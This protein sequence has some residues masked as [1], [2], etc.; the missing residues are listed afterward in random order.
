MDVGLIALL[1][2]L[3]GL[4]TL[5]GTSLGQFMVS[6]PL[7]AGVLTGWVLGDPGLGLL[8]GGVLEVFFIPAFPV[9]GAEFPE[10]GAPTIAA[11]ATASVA[12]G[13]GGLAVGALLGFLL[14]R[15]GGLSVRFRRK[16]NGR[17]VADP[18]RESVPG[19]EIVRRHLLCIFLDFL[20]G[21]ALTAAGVAAGLWVGMK[22]AGAWPLNWQGT[23]GL[24]ILGAAFPAGAL[25][26]GLGGWRRRGILFGTGLLVF[27]VGGLIL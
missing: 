5:D 12:T 17:L 6:R 16:V 24:L 4:L 27:L 25:L 14:T 7:V 26:K 2:L 22:L 10:G 19:R 20:R 3:G 9:G 11:V 18:S 8:I 21:A 13:P 15:L 1:A 23:V